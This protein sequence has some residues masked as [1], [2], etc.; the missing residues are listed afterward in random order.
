[1]IILAEIK[2]Q[3]SC[4]QNHFMCER[5]D[6]VMEESIQKA[7]NNEYPPIQI[8]LFESIFNYFIF[9]PHLFMRVK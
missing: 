4:H 7:M 6:F 8:K 2:I 9:S 1:M 5:S 3:L